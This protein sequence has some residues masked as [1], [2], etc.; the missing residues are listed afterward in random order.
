[1][2]FKQIIAIAIVMIMAISTMITVL[3][4]VSAQYTKMPDRDTVTTVGVTP[5]L[6]GLGQEVI[7]NVITYPG[8]SGPT[9]EGQS[10]ISQLNAGFTN[11]SV[12]MTHP[13]G[14]IET[15]KPID[16]TLAQVGIFEPGRMQIVGHLMFMYEPTKLGTY[17]ITA[18]FPGQTYTTDTISDTAKLSVFYKPSSARAP[19]N[20]TVQ[21]DPVSGGIIDGSPWSPLPNRYWENPVSVD[22]REWAQISGDWI[23]TGYDI[24]GSFYNPYTTAPNSP[25]ILWARQVT[26]SGLPGGI[27]GSLPYDEARV[28]NQPVIDGKIYRNA[29]RGYFE[30]IDLRTGEKL[31]EAPGGIELAQRLDVPFQTASQLN[32]GGIKSWLWGGTGL[33]QT[34][35]GSDKWYRY[36][37]FNGDILQTIVNVPRDL[38]DVKFEDGD[39][40]VWIVQSNT[41]LWN[42]TV[43]LKIPYLNLIKWN[44][45]KMITTVGRTQFYSNDWRDGIVWNV[46]AVQDDIVSIGDHFFRAPICMPYRDANVVI[47]RSPNAQQIMAGYDYTTGAF[48]WKNN[49]TVLNIDILVQGVATS[50][51]GPHIMKDGASAAHVAYDVKTGKEIW[52]TSEGELPWSL[53]PSYPY[54]Y[55]DGVTFMGYFDGYVY[56]YDIENGKQ[57][58]RS[59]FSGITLENIANTQP[60]NGRS[61]VVGADNKLYFASMTEYQLKPRT[62]FTELICINE[63]TGQFIWRLP[64]GILARAIADGYLIGEDWDNGMLYCIGK[65][66]TATTLNAPGSGVHLGQSVTLSGTILDMSPGKPNTA[67]IADQDMSMWMDYLY[68]QNATLINNP[69]QAQGVPVSLSVIDAN[70][71]LRDIG[72]TTSNHNGF[73]SYQWVPDIEGKYTVIATFGG[74]ESYWPS[75]ANAAFSVDP[76]TTTQ[77]PTQP[78]NPPSAAETYLLPGI[79]AIIVA[80][81]IVGALILMAI[82][83][84]P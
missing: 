52:R 70:G 48:L 59:D 24:L 44:F 63:T 32:E 20:F 55:N 64:I 66:M 39:P 15:F 9:Y 81:A 4:L 49:A 10:L 51:S 22:N 40:I 50:P 67:A 30:C 78:I 57:V 17:S 28:A 13:D 61:G 8:P 35:T 82:K 12:T 68:G 19:T 43:P 74:S 72:T 23:Q 1:L 65:G 76:L 45:S 73:Y 46:S 7:I 58:W 41:A 77:A 14:Q 29:K 60:F 53:I 80:I 34:G 79:I 71:N 21:Q 36:S 54:V 26:D 83:K 25:H 3:P 69:P 16:I 11:V 37:T 6:I 2:L 5:T 33:S 18:S 62:R 42:T 84:R 38:S 47:V 27:W 56:A 31:W 75:Q